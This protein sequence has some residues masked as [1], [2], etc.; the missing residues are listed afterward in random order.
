MS[1]LLNKIISDINPSNYNNLKSIENGNYDSCW[2][3]LD[4]NRQQ[5]YLLHYFYTFKT[6]WLDGVEN[7]L[8]SVEVIELL[9]N[10]KALDL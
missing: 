6:V 4:E 1:E 5:K 3:I 7:I 9:K 10:T 8:D 2:A